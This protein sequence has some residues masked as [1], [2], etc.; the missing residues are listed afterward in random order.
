M[1]PF[2]Y[3]TPGSIDTAYEKFATYFCAAFAGQYFLK[4]DTSVLDN[5]GSASQETRSL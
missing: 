4:T 1:H 2:R 3:G 5:P